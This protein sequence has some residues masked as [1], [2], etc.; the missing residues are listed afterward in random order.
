MAL[1]LSFYFNLFKLSNLKI[2]KKIK[3]LFSV[4]PTK[5]TCRKCCLHS[6]KS[7]ENGRLKERRRDRPL[8]PLWW[9]TWCRHSLMKTPG[10]WSEYLYLE[11]DWVEIFFFVYFRIDNFIPLFEKLI[12]LIRK[13]FKLIKVCFLKLFLMFFQAA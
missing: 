1:F 5:R 11:L 8:T 6:V 9:T 7:L 4:F 2:K 13:S 12:N 10:I 3:I